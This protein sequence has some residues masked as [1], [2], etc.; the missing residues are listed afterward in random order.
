MSCALESAR[1]SETQPTACFSVSADADPGVM[2]R[3]LEV[4]AKRGLVPTFWTSRVGAERD[5][6][7]D[8]QMRGMESDLADYVAQTLRQIVGVEVVL[9]SEKRARLTGT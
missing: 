7:I 9:T 6:T 2:P 5:L 8:I 4:F 1:S 3:V